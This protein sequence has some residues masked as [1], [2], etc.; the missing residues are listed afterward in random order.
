MD[1]LI[2]YKK[3]DIREEACRG[4]ALHTYR[5]SSLVRGRHILQLEKKNPNNLGKGTKYNMICTHG[6]TLL[7]S[8]L[9]D[10]YY[11]ITQLSKSSLQA[12]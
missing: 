9:F 12:H 3:C 2:R 1:S 6:Y 11:D 8:Y 10:Y 4:G 5:N 7:Y